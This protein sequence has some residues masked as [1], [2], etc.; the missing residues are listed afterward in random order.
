MEREIFKKILELVNEGHTVSFEED[1]GGNT[2]TIYL[3]DIHT[4]CGVPDGDFDTLIRSLYDLLINKR[5]L[6]W[7]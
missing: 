7:A 6:S 2:I 3:D 4:H 1:L 5:G